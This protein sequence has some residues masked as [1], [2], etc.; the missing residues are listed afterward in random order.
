MVRRLALSR[1]TF[2][3]I[4]HTRPPIVTGLGRPKTVAAQPNKTSGGVTI[5]EISY[6]TKK[7]ARV[8]LYVAGIL[9]ILAVAHGF[10]PLASTR[11]RSASAL[12]FTAA[13]RRPPLWGQVRPRAARALTVAD[14]IRMVSL[15][16]NTPLKVGIC[17]ATGA[18]G[19]EIIGVLE[20]RGF[21]VKELRLFG[22]ERSAGR[23]VSTKWGD[24]AIEDFSVEA[25]S[26][27]DVVFVSVSGDFSKQYC[28]AMAAGGAVV[29][30]NSSAFRYEPDV[31]LCVPEI[32]AEAARSSKR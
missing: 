32:N 27:L 29:I 30:D 18:V 12:S 5:F 22:S 13:S 23:K 9:A 31:C 14:A 1:V 19:K 21:P 2:S 17:G 16:A 6:L 11:L 8:Q 4:H 26:K 15:P 28:D 24:I 10:A 20:K 7:M 3:V 25:A